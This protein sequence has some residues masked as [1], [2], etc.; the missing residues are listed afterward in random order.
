MSTFPM[1]SMQRVLT[2][3]GHQE[4][5]RVPF[6]LLTTLHGA[7]ELGLSIRDYFGQA[8]NVAEGQ[9]RL[10]AR[11]GH[12]CYYPFYYA[13]AEVEAFGGEVIFRDDGPP[14]AGEPV[15][16]RAEEIL[17]L[18]PPVIADQPVLVRVLETIRLLAAASRG[19]APIIGVA[20]APFSL[21]VMQLGFEAYLRLIYER[22]DLFARL[23]QVNEE[24]CVAWATAQVAAGANAICYFDPVSSSTIVTPEMYRTTGYAVARRVLPRIP[25]PV[26]LHFASGACLP[27]L[28]DVQQTGAALVGVSSLEDLGALKAACRGKIGLFGNL[29]GITMARWTVAE[30]EAEVKR[31]LAAAGAGGGYI[32]ADNHGEIPWQVRD[33]VLLAIADAVRRWGAYPLQ[34]TEHDAA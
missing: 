21:P 11:Y 25:A 33:E 10:R 8:R 9:L 2:A 28:P 4:P 19:E 20:L 5:D 6:F 34:I 32:L 23:M 1:T 24:F 31:C 22:P 3:L 12:D 17:T 16:R 14:N 30:A 26:A 15:L 29:N 27:I 13:A 18:A 7:Q